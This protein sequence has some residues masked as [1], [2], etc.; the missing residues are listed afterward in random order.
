MIF[1]L[2]LRLLQLRNKTRPIPKVAGE[3]TLKSSKPKTV[4]Q[5]QS[6]IDVWVKEKS[7]L[8]ER[9]LRLFKSDISNIGPDERLGVASQCVR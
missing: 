3:Q 2:R 4:S 1:V 9:S 6:G 7:R 5:R 8:D